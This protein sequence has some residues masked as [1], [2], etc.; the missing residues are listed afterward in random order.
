A[1]N[2]MEGLNQQSQ[3]IVVQAMHRIVNKMLHEPTERLKAH[4]AS[5]ESLI[6]VQAIQDL[7]ALDPSLTAEEQLDCPCSNVR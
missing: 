4:A 1:L 6:Y 5:G 3:S 2:R 7:F